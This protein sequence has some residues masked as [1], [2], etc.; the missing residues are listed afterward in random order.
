MQRCLSALAFFLLLTFS[1]T[2]GAHAQGNSAAHGHN[3]NGNGGGGGSGGG[4]SPPPPPGIGVQGIGVFGPW[5]AS[6]AHPQWVTGP[7]GN[8]VQVWTVPADYAY[9]EGALGMPQGSIVSSGGGIAMDP[10]SRGGWANYEGSAWSIVE[11]QFTSGRGPQLWLN[12]P[13]FPQHEGL[14]LRQ[15]ATGVFNSHYQ[16]VAQ[17]LAGWGYTEV[18]FRPIWEFEGG[19]YEWGWASGFQ[20]TNTYCSDFIGAF[21]QMVVAI[22][23][24]MPNATFA[25]N[26]ADGTIMPNWQAC[27]PGDQDTDVV[28]I[29]TYDGNRSQLQ[30]AASRWQQD[31]VPGITISQGLALQ[32]R[33]GWAVP[34]WAI[35]RMGDNPLFVANMAAA[36]DA[37]RAYGLAAFSGYW[38][39]GD[40]NSGY[41]GYMNTDTNP[42]SWA[43]FTK[44]FH[45]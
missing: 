12:I 14:T 37:Y 29:D 25:F 31:Q 19:W 11:W 9:W 24:V 1:T 10:D 43:E 35:G 15:A 45:L 6:I 44:D 16:T 17:Q 39:S 38:N 27:Y 23:A 40:P 41:A 28:A 42:L 32:H 4:G 22:R 13:P 30:P 8:P 20:N 2:T 21:H 7:D 36:M 26:A 18:T 5:D 3:G 33:K 34:E